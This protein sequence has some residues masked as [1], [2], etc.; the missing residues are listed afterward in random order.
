[1]PLSLDEIAAAY[2]AGAERYPD[3]RPLA[4]DAAALWRAASDPAVRE[5][6][7]VRTRD[8]AR[9][10]WTVD[11][12]REPGRGRY[13]QFRPRGSDL[14]RFRASADGHRPDEWLAI[15]PA[16][17]TAFALFAAGAHGGEGQAED[18]ELDLAIPK[19]ADRMVRDAQHRGLVFDEDE[20]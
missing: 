1:M 12:R 15:P 5:V 19:L 8:S 10:E 4:R 18:R 17:W 16:E 7:S 13:L 6:G 9:R 2:R 11:V 14:E 20:Q 3:G